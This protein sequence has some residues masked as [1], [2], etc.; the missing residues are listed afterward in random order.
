MNE[1]F[2]F[3]LQ[4]LKCGNIINYQVSEGETMPKTIDWKKLKWLTEDPKGFNLVHTGIVITDEILIQ[5]GFIY[6]KIQ[7]GNNEELELDYCSGTFSVFHNQYYNHRLESKV[8]LGIELI[9]VHQL[10]NLF[11]SISGQW[12]SFESLLQK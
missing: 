3:S 10:Q 12:L 7:F 9:F 8:L 2:N 6:N 4:D 11:Y 1:L 5:F